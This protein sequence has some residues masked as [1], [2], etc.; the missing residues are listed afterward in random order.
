MGKNKKSVENL[1]R[2][3]EGKKSHTEMQGYYFNGYYRTGMTLYTES[4]SFKGTTK[5]GPCKH[6]S[7]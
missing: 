2:Q 7:V 1:L 5:R 6:G 4:M 3:L